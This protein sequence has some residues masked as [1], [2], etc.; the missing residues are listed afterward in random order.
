MEI[1]MSEAW[2]T[3]YGDYPIRL[4]NFVVEDYETITDALSSERW[5]EL[6]E[7]LRHYVMNY[8]RKIISYQ[9]GVQFIS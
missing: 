9:Y 4:L 6:E 2:H 1:Y 5:E 8:T 3:A 7:K